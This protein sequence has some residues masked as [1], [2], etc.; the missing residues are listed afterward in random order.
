M[1]NISKEVAA[2][3]R[4]LYERAAQPDDGIDLEELE[5]EVST[6]GYDEALEPEDMHSE[7]PNEVVVRG[8]K[9]RVY[10]FNNFPTVFRIIAKARAGEKPKDLFD[11]AYRAS[12]V[13]RHYI[14]LIVALETTYPNLYKTMN[15]ISVTESTGTKEDN[16][17]RIR[18][19]SAAYGAMAKF[20]KQIDEN[21]Q[22]S[23][24]Y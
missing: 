20:G 24:L 2:A 5:R 7:Q 21:F 14:E 19:S 15:Q 4:Q 22:L 16:A 10:K 6:I 23:W 9:V 18:N 17:E 11:E 3:R 1:E 12:M 13:E 8:R